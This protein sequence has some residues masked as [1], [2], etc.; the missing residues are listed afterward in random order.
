M[1]VVEVFIA[2]A[3]STEYVSSSPLLTYDCPLCFLTPTLLVPI[4]RIAVAPLF[5]DPRFRKFAIP[6]GDVL[7]DGAIVNK[8]YNIS[9]RIL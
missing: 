1:S 8:K 6:H 3:V 4:G 2:T 7:C 9:K 5:V